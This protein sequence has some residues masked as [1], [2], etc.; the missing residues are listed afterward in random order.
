MPA[1]FTTKDRS[2]AIGKIIAATRLKDIPSAETPEAILLVA[3]G[4]PTG[5]GGVQGVAGG[6]TPSLLTSPSS[7]TPIMPPE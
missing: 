4:W 1:A 2:D 7:V 3:G 6:L 5:F